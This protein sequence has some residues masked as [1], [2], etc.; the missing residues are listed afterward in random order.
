MK[1][2]RRFIQFTGLSMA[3]A[4]GGP[5]IAQTAPVYDV[6][7]LPRDHFSQQDDRSSYSS[8]MPMQES[9]SGIVRIQ[10]EAPSSMGSSNVIQRLQRLEEQMRN[11]PNGE[12]V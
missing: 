1:P 4:M 3:M 12:A 11:S 7:N 10:N 2:I 5:V 6:D 8:A 9:D